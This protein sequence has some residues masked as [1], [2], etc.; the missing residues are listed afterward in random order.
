MQAYDSGL[1]GD[2]S[3]GP[4]AGQTLTAFCIQAAHGGFTYHFSG[5]GGSIPSAPNGVCP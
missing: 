1:S 5:P 4:V 3:V 2:V